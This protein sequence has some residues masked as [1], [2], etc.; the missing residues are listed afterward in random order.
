MRR[1][2]PKSL[3]DICTEWDKVC[4]KRQA[5]IDQGQDV[6]LSLVTAP[7]IT[8]RVRE[9]APKAILDVGCGTGYVTSLL[10]QEAPICYGIDASRHS[11]ELAKKRYGRSG[12][13]FVHS[14]LEDFSPD[15][16]FDCC[17]SNMVLNCAPDL[18]G[19][20][21]SIYK[22]LPS[23]GVFLTMIPHPCFWPVYWG[24][25]D[26]SWFH[27]QEEMFIEHDFSISL[28]KAMGKSTYIHRPLSRYIHELVSAGFTIEEIE[29]PYPSNP[30]PAGYSYRYPRFLFLKCKRIENC[31]SKLQ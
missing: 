13:H 15:I 5:T 10:A 3:N 8:K 19:T 16:Q 23:N 24:L 20:L 29:E 27:Y 4:E 11:I 17:V 28:V 1:V 2:P 18:Q 14:A 12:L 9:E 7:C 30:V 6:S 21:Q 26:K 31:N 25:Q 22:L